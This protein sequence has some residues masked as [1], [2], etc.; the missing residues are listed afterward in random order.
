M[1]SL[2][3]LA[4]LALLP[5][6]VA[7]GGAA[8][9]AEFQRAAPSYQALA[10]DVSDAATAEGMGALALA[11]DPAAPL[12]PVADACHPHLFLRSHALAIRV[13]RHL[14]KL[15]V[16]VERLVARKADTVTTSKAVWERSSGQVEARLSVTRESDTTFS[17]LLEMRQAGASAWVTVMTGRIDRTGA[18]GPHQGAGA[19]TLDL[20]ALR[21]VIPGEPASGTIA[22]SFESFADRRKI[23]VHALDV[24]WDLLPGDDVPARARDAHYV[25]TRAPGKGGSLKIAD[26]M[27][28]LCPQVPGQLPAPADV[29]LVSRWYRLA[30]GAV[31]GRS[32]G[33]ITGGQLASAT[34]A[35]AK[36]VGLTCHASAGEMKLQGE[37]Y[38]LVKSEDAGGATLEGFA[39]P[40]LDPGACDPALNPPGGEVPDLASSGNDYDFSKIDFTTDD[41]APFPGL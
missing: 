30:D 32:D 7:C 24:S 17:W 3:I 12:P 35:I 39:P 11:V 33:A 28:F 22:L 2:R 8:D 13:N 6:L 38:W 4:V 20:T 23:A 29:K 21:S 14:W 15:L 40:G 34:P 1:K 26:Q 25:Y 31:H 16:H 19:A 41:P 9:S 36:V 37:N 10:L 5:A 27:L 18:Q